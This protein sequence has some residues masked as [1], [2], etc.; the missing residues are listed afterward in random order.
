MNS[1]VE[2]TKTKFVDLD[3]AFNFV[4]DD[5]F[6]WQFIIFWKKDY[7]LMTYCCKYSLNYHKFVVT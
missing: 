4:V 1:Y 6:I 3:E 5:F 2:W 7:G